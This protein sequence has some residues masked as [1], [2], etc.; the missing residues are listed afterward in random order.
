MFKA[1]RSMICSKSPKFENIFVPLFSLQSH[2]LVGIR[3]LFV[4][5]GK[6]AFVIS[7]PDI[8]FVRHVGYGL[9]DAEPESQIRAAYQFVVPMGSPTPIPVI[10]VWK[11]VRLV[12]TS[13]WAIWVLVVSVSREQNIDELWFKNN[14]MRKPRTKACLHNRAMTKCKIS[15]L[16]LSTFLQNYE[17]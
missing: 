9:G 16:T 7:K 6:N 13:A 17:E 11:L 2:R 8:R 5:V 15:S 3:K 10:C 4:D 12:C 14:R 1:C